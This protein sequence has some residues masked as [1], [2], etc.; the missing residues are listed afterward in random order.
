MQRRN[1]VSS[2]VSELTRCPVHRTAPHRTA[3]ACEATKRTVVHRLQGRLRGRPDALLSAHRHRR[4]QPFVIACVALSST[5]A[6]PAR[7]ALSESSTSTCFPERFVVT[8]F[9]VLIEG[10]RWPLPALCLVAQGRCPPRAHRARTA[11]AERTARAHA[12]RPSSR[13]G[14]AARGIN[15]SP[16]AAARSLPAHFNFER[17]HEALGQRTPSEFYIPRWRAGFR[18]YA[19]P[20]CLHERRLQP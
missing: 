9:A 7:R 8:R 14:N 3:R 11:R 12:S 17:P 19:R 20:R 16:A 13:D 10:R 15:R 1:K 2:E 5:Q 18:A 6:E 4:I